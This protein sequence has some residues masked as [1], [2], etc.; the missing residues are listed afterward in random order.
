VSPAA[1]GCHVPIDRRQRMAES[2]SQKKRSAL[3]S[4]GID[5]DN[6]RL[7]E[8][9]VF[10]RECSRDGRTKASNVRRRG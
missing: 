9:L 7:G 10:D 4:A 5:P 8:P 6:L 1:A 3:Q 2:A